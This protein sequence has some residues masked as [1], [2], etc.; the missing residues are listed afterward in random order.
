MNLS[1][2]HN[3]DF[4]TPYFLSKMHQKYRKGFFK[5]SVFKIIFVK[6]ANFRENISEAQGDFSGLLLGMQVV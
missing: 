4:T 3:E 2:F 1:F 6:F 5:R